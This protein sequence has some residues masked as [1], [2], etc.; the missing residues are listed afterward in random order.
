VIHGARSPKGEGH[1]N[2]RHGLAA[3]HWPER[4]LRMARRAARDPELF[5]TR[6]LLALLDALVAIRMNRLRLSG[7]DPGDAD[8]SAMLRLIDAKLAA[9]AQHDR[10]QRWKTEVVTRSEMQTFLRG[11]VRSAQLRVTDPVERQLFADDWRTLARQV[12]VDVDGE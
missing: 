10:T 7:R 1:W 4:V 2:W 9:I 11:M 3:K 8:E 12:G 5:R 6:G